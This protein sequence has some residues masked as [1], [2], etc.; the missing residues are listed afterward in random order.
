MPKFP[1]PKPGHSAFFLLSFL[2]QEGGN[3]PRRRD[4]LSA[5]QFLLDLRIAN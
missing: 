4:E 3:K 1:G 2:A 5:D